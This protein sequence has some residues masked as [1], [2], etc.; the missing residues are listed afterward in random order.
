MQELSWSVSYRNKLLFNIE[1]TNGDGTDE[2]K[3]ED[4]ASDESDIG[5]GN[6]SRCDE[7]DTTSNTSGMTDID[8]DMGDGNSSDSRLFRPLL[9]EFYM[10]AFIWT[11]CR[12]TNVK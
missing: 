11:I 4:D 10:Q 9:G 6:E 3:E 8:D 12:V 1:E 2:R 7:N 5:D